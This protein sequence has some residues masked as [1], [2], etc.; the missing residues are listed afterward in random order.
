MTPWLFSLARSLPE[1]LRPTRVASLLMEASGCRWL[2]RVLLL[3]ERAT[4]RPAALDDAG[5]LLRL[6]S[7]PGMSLS[8]FT[9]GLKGELASGAR[10][11]AESRGAIVGTATVSDLGAGRWG[12]YG[13]WVKP[14]YRHQGLGRRLCAASLEHVRARK[15]ASITLTVNRRAWRAL[16]LYRGLGFVIVGS[17]EDEF[18]MGK[19]LQ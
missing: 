9:E 18:T 11:V 13:V 8:E 4:V 7:A 10:M 3:R 12:L 6:N 17:S 19:F 14:F 15:G 2:I 5:G 16:G 1:P